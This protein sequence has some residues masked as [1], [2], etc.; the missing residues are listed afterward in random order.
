MKKYLVLEDGTIYTGIAFGADTETIG[1]LVFTTAMSGY[2]EAISDPASN[3]LILSFAAPII[4]NAGI[5]K[6]FNQADKIV[7]RGVL[8]NQLADVIGNYQS[9]MSLGEYLKAEGV[10]GIKDIDTRSL[11]LKLRKE[12]EMKAAIVNQPDAELVKSIKDFELT[13]KELS[14]SWNKE[15]RE[16]GEGGKHVVV[17]DC[18]VGYSLIRALNKHGLKVSVVPKDF[19]I[20]QIENLNP[21]GI[22]VSDGPGNPEGYKDVIANVKELQENYPLLGIGLGHQI[23]ALANG[24]K[25]KAMKT[26]QHGFNYLVKDL[27]AKKNYFTAQAH[28]FEVDGST[29]KDTKLEVTQKGLHD[30]SIQGLKHRYFKAASVQ[31]HPE[32]GPG[33]NDANFILDDFVKSL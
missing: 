3:G 20:E 7:A 12:G 5:N 16:F 33:P 27:E 4:G 10:P 29:I 21:N 32:G 15:L 14:E 17:I 22:V 25:I 31:F 8:V 6:K 1:K 18:G 2:Q 9:E 26:G 11:T 13:D 23:L 30:D 19:S 28:S 24:A